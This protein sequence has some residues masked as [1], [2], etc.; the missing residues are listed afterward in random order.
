MIF[1]IVPNLNLNMYRNPYQFIKL[2]FT[3]VGRYFG[4]LIYR[5][6]SNHDYCMEAKNLSDW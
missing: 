3:R 2:P 6:I 5:D 4:V 1:L